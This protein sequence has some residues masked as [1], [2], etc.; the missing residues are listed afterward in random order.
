M[1]KVNE[2]FVK[3]LSNFSESLESLVE[4]LEK[5]LKNSEVDTVSKMLETMDKKLSTVVEELK[6]VKEETKSIKKDTGD[7]LKAVK[8]MKSSKKEGVSTDLGGKSPNVIADSVKSMVLIAGGVLAIGLAFKIVGHVD[9]LSVVALSAAIYVIAMTFEKL[10]KIEALTYKKV[11]MTSAVLVIMAGAILVSGM[12]LNQMPNIGIMTMFSVLFVSISMS[13]AA[14]GLSLAMGH[15]HIKDLPKYMILPTIIPLMAAGIVGA[16]FILQKMPDVTWQN[17]LSAGLVGLALIPVAFA[18]ALMVKG[19]KNTDPVDILMA[20]ATIPIMSYA[21][22]L[23]SGILNKIKPIEWKVVEYSLIVGLS[24]LPFAAMIAGLSKLKVGIESI[25][26]G[27]IGVVLISGAIMLS[28]WIL[29]VG[30]YDKY[31]PVKWSAGVGLS[32]LEFGL[33]AAGLGLLFMTGVGAIGFALGLIGILAVAGSIV[34][35]SHILKAGVYEKYPSIEWSK[36]VGLSMLAFS[37]AILITAASSPI[38]AVIKFFGGDPT[39]I[40]N[41]VAD[42]MVNVA[43]ILNKFDWATAKTPTKEWAE[44]AGIGIS[45]FASS[46]MTVAAGNAGVAIFDSIATFFGGTKNKT[47]LKDVATSMIEVAKILDSPIWNKGMGHPNKEW[48]EGVG[49][50]ISAFSEAMSFMKGGLF[51]SP[52]SPA[53]YRTMIT[54]IAG[55][56]SAAAQALETTSNIPGFWNKINEG[57]N[58]PSKEWSEGVAT[59]I[60]GFSQAFQIVTSASLTSSNATLMGQFHDFILMVASTMVHVA[61]GLNLAGSDIYTN[62][63]K[64]EWASSVSASISAFVEAFKT[65]KDFGGYSD[66]TETSQSLIYMGN[67]VWSFSTIIKN[68]DAKVFEKDGIINKIADSL[69]KLKKSLPSTSDTA[70]LMQMGTAIMIMVKAMENLNSYKINQLMN[71]SQGMQ[72]M[73]II[74]E[75]KLAQVLT[76]INKKKDELHSIMDTGGY[77]TTMMEGFS[78]MLHTAVNATSGLFGYKGNKTTEVISQKIEKSEKSSREEKIN[79]LVDYVKNIDTNIAKLVGSPLFTGSPQNV[80]SPQR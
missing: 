27:S 12:I 25:I 19:L 6:A 78:D 65:V 2:D 62:Y 45:F 66:V 74:D 31:P 69:T 36:S 77:G 53:Q 7:I 11:V 46:L 29:S 8:E 38:L 24:I 15:I 10:A 17:A 55:G 16:G 26:E 58:F 61:K 41:P 68:I 18:F 3:S 1:S 13:V 72:M 60:G 33:A 47:T 39:K 9:F 70:G 75:Q 23:A 44:G 51:S 52:V 67:S 54:T 35:V 40:L 57:K 56:L 37:T 30:K 14:Y 79:E 21:I 4:I 32:V 63:P 20:C 34:A 76:V 80:N 50:S 22:V 28:S 73:S 48:A 71:L 42:S 5:Q 64:E 59:A 43:R 49:L